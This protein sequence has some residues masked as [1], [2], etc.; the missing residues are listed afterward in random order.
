M[1]E[2]ENYV[3][4][5]NKICIITPIELDRANEVFYF[6]ISLENGK[7]IIIRKDNEKEII[8]VRKKFLDELKD[9]V[10]KQAKNKIKEIFINKV[11]GYI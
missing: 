11:G 7:S 10:L 3:I 8:E 6:E 2:V 9:D 1:I 4:I 5:R